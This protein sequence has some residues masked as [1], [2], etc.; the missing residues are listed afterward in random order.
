MANLAKNVLEAQG[1]K[2]QDFISFFST[3]TTN[4]DGIIARTFSEEDLIFSSALVTF[5]CLSLTHLADNTTSMRQQ[6]MTIYQGNNTNQ[7]NLFDTNPHP[8]PTPLI[9]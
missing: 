3:Q 9:A 5:I 7:N 6:L 4:L 8:P 2:K 1:M